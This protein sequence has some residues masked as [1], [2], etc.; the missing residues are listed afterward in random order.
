MLALLGVLA[1]LVGM[2][3][4]TAALAVLP[5]CLALPLIFR[6]TAPAQ[7]FVALLIALGL[8]VVAG[9]E[10]VYLRDFLEG[11]DWY[12]MNTLFKFSVP[13]WLFLSLASSVALP[14]LWSA[15][16]RRAGGWRGA[17]GGR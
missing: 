17:A 7:G 16:K 5:L 3:R 15:L 2:G 11:G 9:T 8:G 14:A 1:L 4:P 13:A 12:R 6:R 10:L